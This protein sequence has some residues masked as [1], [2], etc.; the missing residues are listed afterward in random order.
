[1]SL[2]D[3]GG[4]AASEGEIAAFCRNVAQAFEGQPPPFA[5]LASKLAAALV[6]AL[7]S[8]YILTGTAACEAAL[9]AVAIVACSAFFNSS[10]VLD[11]GGTAACAIIASSAITAEGMRRALANRSQ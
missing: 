1:V 7:Q 5:E 9:R 2:T 10:L 11:S 6:P 4:A 3:G 8:P